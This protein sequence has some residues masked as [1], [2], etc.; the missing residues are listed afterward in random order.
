MAV[1]TKKRKKI[2]LI[3][4][5]SILGIIVIGISLLMIFFEDIV[6]ARLEARLQEKF[7]TYYTLEFE[8]LEKD[9]GFTT[10]SFRIKN[11]RLITDTTDQEG[12]KIYPIIFFNAEE[13]RIENISTWDILWGK[14]LNLDEIV[15]QQP[16]FAFHERELQN[17]EQVTGEHYSNQ[18][19]NHINIESIKLL[20]GKMQY[21]DFEKKRLVLQNDSVQFEIKKLSLDMNNLVD[22]QNAVSMEDF[23]LQAYKTWYKPLELI[24]DFYMDSLSLSTK[25]GIL[26]MQNFSVITKEEIQKASMSTVNQ[27]EVI[28]FFLEEVSV[29]GYD[30][31]RLYQKNELYVRKVEASGIKI[32]L[33]KNKLEGYEAG[34]YKSLFQ[35]DIRAIPFPILV[36]TIL[37]DD[38][39]FNF[40][41]WNSFLVNPANMFI[42]GMKG[43]LANFSTFKEGN[44]TL[45]LGMEG[46]LM[47]K[48][49]LNWNMKMS[50]QDSISNYGRFWGH[51]KN[52]PFAEINPILGNFINIKVTSGILDRIDFVGRTDSW[53]AYGSVAFRYRNMDFDIYS[54]KDLTKKRKDGFLTSLAKTVI[55]K[56][57]PLPNGDFRTADFQFSRKN[58]EGSLMLWVGG[59]LVGA[60]KT[61]LKDFVLPIV[62]DVSQKKI[63]EE[64]KKRGLSTKNSKVELQSKKNPKKNQQKTKNKK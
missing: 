34:F 37:F 60:V 20:R 43:Y 42:D 24:Y 22:Y 46:K 15:L 54:L 13:L 47:N 21:H 56:N 33:F 10:A 31:D 1:F 53:N 40:D 41:I 4:L 44:D 17:Q 9:I 57:N 35:E 6:T 28:N 7:G 50:I 51:V 8:E 27:A 58:H 12:I 49:F 55:H 45:Y 14:D 52:L 59:V 18:I 5:G 63:E 38:T 39:K 30:F 23:S 62:E 16:Y 29:T 36:D 26:E 48:G 64:L 2:L 3:T 32:D 25:E 61:C 11:A 19:L